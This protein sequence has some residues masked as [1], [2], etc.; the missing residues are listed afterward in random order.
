MVHNHVPLAR[1]A[2]GRPWCIGPAVETSGGGGLAR[3]ATTTSTAG[4]V[5]T[6]VATAITTIVVLLLYLVQLPL[7]LPL[8]G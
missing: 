2:V 8:G 5:L 6:V 7:V 1:V 4:A 3:R